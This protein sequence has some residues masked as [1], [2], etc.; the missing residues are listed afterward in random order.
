[1]RE[2][3]SLVAREN[4]LELR[5]Q[6]F[7]TLKRK[8]LFGSFKERNGRRGW[9]G[10]LLFGY[11]KGLRFLLCAL[12]FLFPRI[13]LGKVP[14]SK[15]RSVEKHEQKN[16]SHDN[17]HKYFFK[18]GKR[19]LGHELALGELFLLC[20]WAREKYCV[21]LEFEGRDALPFFVRFLLADLG[22]IL[23]HSANLFP[24]QEFKFFFFRLLGRLWRWRLLRHT[25]CYIVT[26]LQA[27]NLTV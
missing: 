5:K 11:W 17:A 15:S 9:A 13:S 10:S 7:R 26:L 21:F 19:A 6:F 25:N 4:I 20:P 8:P 3:G 1:M 24:F 12:G 27:N 23:C 2:P 16:S 22:N 18:R 14:E